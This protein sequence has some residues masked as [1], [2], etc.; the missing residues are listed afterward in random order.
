MPHASFRRWAK[1]DRRRANPTPQLLT[2]ARD[3]PRP[4]RLLEDQH[5]LLSAVETDRGRGIHQEEQQW[6]GSTGAG[7]DRPT[8]PIHG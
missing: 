5:Q 4:E 8:T 7:R 3:L 2:V 6:D 1:S